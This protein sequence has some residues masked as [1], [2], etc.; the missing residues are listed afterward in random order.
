MRNAK[1]NNV[2]VDKHRHPLFLKDEVVLLNDSL[3]RHSV[4]VNDKQEPIKAIIRNYKSINTNEGLVWVYQISDIQYPSL[5]RAV[6]EDQLSK[7]ITPALLNFKDLLIH[8][9]KSL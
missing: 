6:F 2:I 8:C 3:Y 9:N 7:L 1:R 5:K 4:G